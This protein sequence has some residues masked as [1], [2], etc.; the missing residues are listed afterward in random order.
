MGRLIFESTYASA[1]AVTRERLEGTELERAR[2]Y[3]RWAL[4][5]VDWPATPAAAMA[6][7]WLRRGPLI[8]APPR[9]ETALAAL[10]GPR[11]QAGLRAAHRLQLA[12]VR[13]GGPRSVDSDLAEDGAFSHDE[14][15]ALTRLA[16]DDLGALWR[17][18][19]ALYPQP[20]EEETPPLFVS[21]HGLE[22]AGWDVARLE[23]PGAAPAEPLP[24]PL[25]SEA[26]RVNESAL[27]L[28]LRRGFGHADFR[29]GQLEAIAALL[30][31]RDAT[32]LLPTGGGKSLIA[33]LSALLLPGT[34][35]VIEPLL[36]VVEDQLASLRRAGIAAAGDA[37]DCEELEAGRLLLVYASPERFESERFRRALR[38]AAARGVPFVAVD[39]AHC[40]TPWGHGFR[41]AL[42][43]VGRRARRWAAGDGVE[44]P[45]LAMT[46]TASPAQLRAASWALGLS[47][48]AT[49]EAP[50]ARP[51]LRF[52]V[53]R[54]GG[55]EHVARLRA[56]LAREARFGPGLV[57]CPAVDGPLG[58]A[59]VREELLVGE[60]V[61][62]GCFT[63]RAPLGADADAW[64]ALKASQA[65]DFLAGRLDW[66]CCTSAFGLGVDVPRARWTA[67][68][69]LADSLES[70]FQQAGRAGRDGRPAVCRVLLHVAD[71]RRARRWLDPGTPWER[72]WEQ[73]CGDRRRDDVWAALALHRAA[74]PGREAEVADAR[75][76][77][78]A[79]GPIAAGR[80]AELAFAG[81]APAAF[82]R[83]AAR[84]EAAGL[85]EAPA[86]RRDGLELVA[87]TDASRERVFE[88]QA[89]A[90]ADVYAR[91]EPARRASLGLLVERLLAE[92]PGAA[93]AAAL[94]GLSRPA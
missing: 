77:A 79:L 29:A 90:I 59:A 23:E 7:R 60:N 87:R 70:F 88:A 56:W 75:L 89:E 37:D 34:A 66:L 10:L 49:I 47:Q 65:R 39:E 1:A 62:A 92:D 80:Q 81:Q 51:E 54:C 74:F 50:L 42:L 58:A 85:I 83:A 15:R 11:L 61:A 84:L 72:A 91:V 36:A 21:F 5:G 76:I 18:A 93:L 41:P 82:E 69:G 78:R 31:Q 44:P 24:V 26:P 38:A 30:R 68:L 16:L 4:E 63:G 94:S 57:F 32:A 86:R 46:G 17:C 40:V 22:K 71:E 8:P 48:P 3:A 52:E 13:A 73:R 35:V 25:A 19:L 20:P 14:A 55:G 6:E 43:S 67:H 27:R 33:Q 2:R 53:E 64:P 12:V 28:L 45:L 9:L